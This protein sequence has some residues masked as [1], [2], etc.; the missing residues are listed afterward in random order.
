MNRCISKGNL[1][2]DDSIGIPKMDRLRLCKIFL[3]RLKT[4]GERGV[5]NIDTYSDT[6][7]V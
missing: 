7:P 1:I 3:V 5:G 4:N 6:G 2:D